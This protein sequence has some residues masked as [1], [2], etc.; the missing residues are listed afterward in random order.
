MADEPLRPPLLDAVEMALAPYRAILPPET[1]AIVRRELIAI[2]TTHPYP[3]ALLRQ[4][5]PPVVLESGDPN[6]QKGS[7]PGPAIRR[8]GR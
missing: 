3:A 4:L 8:G 6:E 5:D 2:L 7:A 1:L